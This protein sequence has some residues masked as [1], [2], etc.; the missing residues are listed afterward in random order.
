MATW[1]AR[2]F[3]AAHGT[4]DERQ[5]NVPQQAGDGS[6]CVS[7]QYWLQRFLSSGAAESVAEWRPGVCA[8]I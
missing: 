2:V 8:K 5:I 7:M 6:A 4:V 3:M 1:L